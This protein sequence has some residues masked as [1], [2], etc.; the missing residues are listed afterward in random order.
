MLISRAL[1]VEGAE[2]GVAD[3][4]MEISGTFGRGSRTG[5]ADQMKEISGTFGRGIKMESVLGNLRPFWSRVL[6]AKMRFT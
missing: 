2:L 6:G 5:V 1:F 3:Q 4:M